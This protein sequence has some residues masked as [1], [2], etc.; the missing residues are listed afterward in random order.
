M[1]KIKVSLIAIVLTSVAGLIH[2]EPLEVPLKNCSAKE[3]TAFYFFKSLEP[4]NK[5]YEQTKAVNEQVMR[6]IES[7]KLDNK[8]S[9]ASQLSTKDQLKLNSLLEK[10]NAYKIRQNIE[11]V[12]FRNL[13]LL[14]YM[15]QIIQVEDDMSKFI[16]KDVKASALLISLV[17]QWQSKDNNLEAPFY[18]VKNPKTCNIFTLSELIQIE[19]A[20]Q[21]NATPE[22]IR[23]L[24]KEAPTLTE[25]VNRDSQGLT[26]L[27]LEERKKYARMK[28]VFSKLSIFKSKNEHLEQIKAVAYVSDLKYENAVEVW[29]KN[30][31]NLNNLDQSLQDKFSANRKYKND[32]NRISIFINVF[33]NRYPFQEFY[34][35]AMRDPSNLFEK[36]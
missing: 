1:Q 30:L 13:A 4:V 16:S 31:G 26:W 18:E 34:E 12:N 9:M 32:F 15:I 11:E 7:K 27:T 28:D 2:C 36:K 20:E 21:I 17:E 23:S 29:E 19:H 3:L 14:I 8:K 35:S 5:Y 33:D 22:E 25:K 24:A 6:F 10:V